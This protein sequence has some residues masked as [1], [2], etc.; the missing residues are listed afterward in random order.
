MP[1]A[2]LAGTGS[3]LGVLRRHPHRPQLAGVA[4]TR[5]TTQQPPT[6]PEVEGGQ[7]ADIAHALHVHRVVPHKV[8]DRA[9]RQ[10]GQ[11]GSEAGKGRRERGHGGQ[12]AVDARAFEQHEPSRRAQPA[13][14]PLTPRLQGR[15]RPRPG[16]RAPAPAHCGR[17]N[18]SSSGVSRMDASS[19]RNSSALNCGARASVRFRASEARAGAQACRPGRGGGR[20]C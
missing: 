2:A 7:G 10:G 20:L 1:A 13:A 8:Q 4:A 19:S 3:A 18:Q 9:W 5:R 12:R 16:P 17:L 11:E 6:H 15:P 14:R